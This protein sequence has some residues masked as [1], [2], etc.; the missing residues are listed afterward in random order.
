METRNCQN[1]K[2]DFTIDPEDFSFYEKIKVPPPT[3]C[4]ECRNIRRTIW[5]NERTLY[6]NECNL[7][8]KGIVS[9]YSPDKPYKIY[10]D[11]CFHGDGW[12]P[13]EHGVDVD[14][15]KPFLQQFMELQLKA[16]RLY[17][18]VFQNHNSEYVNGAAFNKNCYLIFV[19]DYNEDS[20]YS[21]SLVKS[22]NTLD[23]LNSSECELCYG[24][25]SCN[26]CYRVI[27]SEDCQNSQELMFCKNCVNC[28][29]CI[30]CVNQRNKKY[31]IENIQYTKEEYLKK[32]EELYTASSK[33]LDLLKKRFNEF[34]KGSINKYINGFQN[35]DVLGNF[36]NNS[37]NSKFIFNSENVEDS[38]YINHG[39][40]I[41]SVY[42][43][44]VVVDGTTDSYEIVSA[45]ALNNVISGYSIWHDYNVFYSDTCENSNNL[46]GCV[47][48]KNKSYCILNKQYTKEEYENLVP[49]IIKHMEEMPY[50]DR[51]GRTYKYGEFFPAELTPFC[52][53]ETI[54]QEYFPLTKEQALEQGYEWKDKE[55]RSYK[56]DIALE[57]IPDVIEEVKDDITNKIIECGH[58]GNCNHQCTEAFKIIADELKFYKRM[59]LPIPQLCPNCR[60]YERLLQRNPL[61]LWHRSCMC[62]QDNHDH[63]GNCQNEFETS[64]APDRPEKVYCESCYQKEVL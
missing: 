50:T 31:C 32:K 27:F 47:D 63:S 61:K 36:V 60:H 23:C 1:C 12:D 30:L 58:K 25:I 42:D 37:K 4:P 3:F 22:K 46:F 64:Y 28:S 10:C 26:K 44:Y 24:D 55:E 2:K 7:C 57:H 34:K 21:Y 35:Q 14:F 18:L 51:L 8:K 40:K 13:F 48:L 11:K 53:N 54:A 29:D 45:I 43:A 41:K 56:I 39:N 33:S 5:R 9:I 38:K 52:Y 19:S 15:T 16:P 6:K 62:S 20:M 49:K 59:N 17:S